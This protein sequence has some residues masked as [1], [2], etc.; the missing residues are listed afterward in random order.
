[1]TRLSASAVNG[2]LVALARANLSPEN[3]SALEAFVVAKRI[4]ATGRPTDIG[5]VNAVVREVF[6]VLPDHPRGRIQPFRNPTNQDPPRPGWAVAADSGRKTVWNV[7]TRNRPTAASSLFD[8]GDIRDGLRPNAA[9]VLGAR[10]A[11]A[12][13]PIALAVFLLRNEDF[14]AVP[15]RESL[16]DALQREFGI[17]RGELGQ[18]ATAGPAALELEGAPWS[19]EGLLP[20][21]API[22]TPREPPLVRPPEA[23]PRGDL[24]VDERTRRMVL[25]AIASNS[26]V[27]LV[28][29]PGTGKTALLLDA[30]DEI[31]DDPASF[32][33]ADPVPEP[34]VVTPDESWTT[35]DLVGGLTVSGGEL[36]FRQGHVLEAIRQQRWLVLDEANRADMDKIFGGLLTWLSERSVNL[37]PASTAAD[38]CAVQLAWSD[39]PQGEVINLDG[40]ERGSGDPVQFRAGRD[41]RLLGTYNA[42][43]AH[44]VFRFGQAL[45]RRFVQVPLPPLD[46][47][48]FDLALAPYVAALPP[49]ATTFVE[50]VYAAHFNS[51]VPQLRLGQALFL[52]MPAYVARGITREGEAGEPLVREL[53]LESYALNFAPTL[54]RLDPADRTRFGQSLVD[55]EVISA[56]EW[57]WLEE[58]AS[59]LA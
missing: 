4:L 24:Q 37:G 40:L 34:I 43:D 29:P 50:G 26:A 8:A 28:G 1:M 10:I 6:G 55:A 52:R 32:G 46:P 51:P 36:R 2:A 13:D 18:L 14:P 21:L 58:Q 30:V 11:P 48:Q 20:E 17:A 44:R 57:S 27:L 23:T 12:V 5:T 15:T 7:T 3:A 56:T 25:L 33:F 22:E 42:Q 59:A 35:R 39:R 31:R 47:E 16:L 19:P 45:A 53:L 49:L 9:E 41:W 54:G 38:A